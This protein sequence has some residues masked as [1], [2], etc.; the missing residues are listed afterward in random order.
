MKKNVLRWVLVLLA[1]FLLAGCGGSSGSGSD[2]GEGKSSSSKKSSSKGKGGNFVSLIEELAG[3]LDDTPETKEAFLDL[4]NRLLEEGL[5]IEKAEFRYYEDLDVSKLKIYLPKKE[6][7]SRKEILDLQMK[8]FD[9]TWI[10]DSVKTWVWDQEVSEKVA[11]VILEK[12]N[13][14]QEEKD[15]VFDPEVAKEIFT[16]HYYIN[17]RIMNEGTDEE[18]WELGITYDSSETPEM[19]TTLVQQRRKTAQNDA[20]TGDGIHVNIEEYGISFYMPNGMVTNEYSGVLGVYDYYTGEYHGTRPTGVDLTLVAT[21]VDDDMTA[22]TYAKTKS[23]AVNYEGVTELWEKELNGVTWWTGSAGIL[24]YYA[25][26]NRGVIYEF[27]VMDGENLGVTK[28]DVIKLLE[29]TVYL[30]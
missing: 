29:E 5:D 8:Q 26:K 20:P 4:G 23:R 28:A 7:K 11:K 1:I 18:H 19:Y 13:L 21:G 30:Y 9:G 27:Y 25:A 12:V 17:H 10:M 16:T 2:D 22:E 6:G 15:L 3:K 24:T 14:S